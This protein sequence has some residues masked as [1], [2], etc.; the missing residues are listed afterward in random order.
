MC[1][2]GAADGRAHAPTHATRTS[3]LA[4]RRGSDNGL[5]MRCQAVT[6]AMDCVNEPWMMSVNLNLLTEAGHG[7]IDGSRKG[8]LSVAPQILQQLVA[9]DHVS[10]SLSEIV[11]DLEFLVGQAKIR[12][13]AH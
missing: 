4:Q 5:T 12:I 8:R 6:V 13:V 10:L 1:R 3:A 2:V 7:G 9:V 11:E